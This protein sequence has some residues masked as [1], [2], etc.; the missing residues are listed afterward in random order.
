MCTRCVPPHVIVWSNHIAVFCN[1][2]HCMGVLVAKTVLKMETDTCI[3]PTA[4][5]ALKTLQLYFSTPPYS[6]K[7]SREETSRILWFCV[8]S[9]KFFVNFGGVVSFGTAKASN[10]R[11]K[12][13]S[14]KVFPYTVCTWCFISSIWLHH[15][16]DC[17][18]VGHS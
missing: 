12:F 4:A 1:V 10:P 15:L 18:P 17:I 9:R 8:H 6:R 13:S 5:G 3:F 11:R 16:A 2:T 14:S 7:I